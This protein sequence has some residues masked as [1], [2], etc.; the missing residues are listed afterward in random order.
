[1]KLYFEKI[2]N[3]FLKGK[4]NYVI[5]KKLYYN[6]IELIVDKSIQINEND[7]NEDGKKYYENAYIFIKENMEKILINK[8]TIIEHIINKKSKNDSKRNFNFLNWIN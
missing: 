2:N 3:Q 8:K 4:V 7:K 6:M 1:M 5:M